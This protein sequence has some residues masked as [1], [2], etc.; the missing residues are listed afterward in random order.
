MVSRCIIL[1]VAC[2]GATDPNQ[3]VL[4]LDFADAVVSV[5]LEPIPEVETEVKV[6]ASTLGGSEVVSGFPVPLNRPIASLR[7]TLISKLNASPAHMWT[8][9]PLVVNFTRFWRGFFKA[10][11][12]A[13]LNLIC[14]R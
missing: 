2:P 9:V 6:T 3:C 1:R 12:T 5:D 13:S 4:A 7:A 10:L 14:G 11:F 8:H